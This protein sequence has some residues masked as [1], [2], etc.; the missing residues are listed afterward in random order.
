VGERRL[1]P[2]ALRRAGKA[3]FRGY[4][5]L[6]SGL[7]PLPEF[8]LIG[9]KRGGS[10]TLWKYLSAHP[11]IV[12][13]FPSARW[14]PAQYDMKGVHYFD[15]KFGRSAAWYRGHFR[16]AWARERLAR[17]RGGPVVAGEA[18]PY[19][20][21]HPC[22]PERVAS[23]APD[24]RLLVVL[25]D[26][27]QRA[28]SHYK[29]QVQKGAETLSFGAALDAETG[30]LQ[31][32][33]ALLR[34][35]RRATHFAHEHHGYVRQG[36]YADVLPGWLQHFGRERLHIL[37]SEELFADPQGEMDRAWAFL[38]LES[39]AL[40]AGAPWNTIAAGP[41]PAPEQDLL[42]AHFEEPNARLAALL[43]R[44]LPW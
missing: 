10:T 29:E 30:R 16:T 3:A 31:G 32:A 25:R 5:T 43:G 38:G 4:G 28:W 7:R 17:R 41:L 14:L 13:L 11:G 42:R 27:V 39:V 40:L 33:E 23:V 2:P 12:P 34:R 20:L 24:A 15:T 6:T 18:S 19:Y 36:H 8:L 9:T 35:D 22:A 44:P 37:V 21:F 1:L 26:P